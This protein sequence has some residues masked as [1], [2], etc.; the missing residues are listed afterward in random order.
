MKNILHLSEGNLIPSDFSDVGQ[1]N[2]YAG[3]FGDR[4]RYTP[5]TDWL[6]FDS[7]CWRENR[8]DAQAMAQA[9]TEEQ[10]KQAQ[11]MRRCALDAV[12]AAQE[13]NDDAGIK[14]AKTDEAKA[15]AFYRYALNRR[16]SAAI[17]ATLTEARPS[18]QVQPD[19]LD[20]DPFLLNTPAGTVD[21]RTGAL[22]AHDP[23]DFCTKITGTSPSSEG[24]DLFASFLE[25]I[26]VGDTELEA[27]LQAVAGMFALGAVFNECL[28]IAYGSGRNG[29]STFFN[30]LG[31]VLG[32]YSGALSAETL[33]VNCRQNKSPE[34]AELR[35]KR[36]VIAAEL[37]EGLR[38]D[39]AVVKKLCS[40]DKVFA[41]KKYRDPMQFTPSHSILLF[42]NHLPKVGTSDAGTWRRLV[43]IPFR[44]SIT[45]AGDR[46]D[47]GS[48]LFH[49]AGGAVLSWVIEGARRFIE[50]GYRLDQPKCV[51]DA[52]AEYR[53][54]NDWLQA[55]IAECCDTSPEYIQPSGA[56]YM[57]YLHFCEDSHEFRR[58][59]AD[60]RRALEDAGYACKHTKRGKMFLG[61]RAR[62][63]GVSS[64][65]ETAH[66]ARFPAL[67][68]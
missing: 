23:A 37:E 59:Q 4:L 39:T 56:L 31:R 41:T 12:M 11:S 58:N 65:T 62:P 28:T 29:K 49:Q 66:P 64:A 46:K 55:F 43:V 38:L 24:A 33:T 26:T 17:S 22:K 15:D 19:Q 40:T 20:R 25:T 3:I 9:L 36:F 51:R 1:A 13:R 32:Y 2:L 42:T 61:L 48:Y 63:L 10:V 53:S 27:Y 44:A 54:D 21:Q 34:F 8:L 52:I 47:F 67:P 30:L 57:H 5:A 16:K 45:D 50:A 35:G 18:L 7:T 68:A 6:V 60:F 14:S